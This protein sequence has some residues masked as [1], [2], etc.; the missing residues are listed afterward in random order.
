M[1]LEWGLLLGDFYALPDPEREW[2]VS[3]WNAVQE[4]RRAAMR[5]K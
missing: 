3:G 2:M 4:R 5:R 1:L